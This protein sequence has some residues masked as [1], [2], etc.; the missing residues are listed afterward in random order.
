MAAEGDGPDAT[1]ANIREPEVESQSHAP[2]SPH[3]EAGSTHD[4]KRQR[5]HRNEPAE[6]RRQ[7]EGGNSREPR[8][9]KRYK[10]SGFG[11]KG[12]DSR[13]KRK[14]LGRGEY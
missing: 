9:A 12:R 2:R 1:M 6:T 5:D 3:D 14:D 7:R 4:K 13:D 11:G 8:D 10:K